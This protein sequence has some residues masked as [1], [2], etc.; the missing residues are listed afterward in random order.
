MSTMA[1]DVTPTRSLYERLG[2]RARITMLVDEIIEEHMRNPCIAARFLPD[3]EQPERLA[4][5]KGHL[6]DFFVSGSGGPG[7]YCGRSMPEAHRGLNISEAEYMAAVDDILTVLDRHSTDEQTR[8]DVLA[9]A[10]S[11]KNDIM[12]V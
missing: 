3:R 9:I 10:F 5:V 4:E 12:H 7:E 1:Q 8:K 6:V 2:G 11:L